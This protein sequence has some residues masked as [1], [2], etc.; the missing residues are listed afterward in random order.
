[1]DILKPRESFRFGRFEW[2]I[3][4]AYCALLAWTIAHH[5]P[6]ADEAQSWLLARDLSLAAIYGKYLHYEGTPGLWYLFLWFLVRLHVG[7]SLMHWI[8]G[9]V[10]AAGTWVFLRYSPFP[11][12]LRATLPF[13]FY[14]AYQYAV[15][16]RSYIA[17]P[18]CVF[19]A[20]TLLRNPLRHLMALA[21]V[22]GLLANLCAQG[23]V[24]SAGFAL[25][26]AARLLRRRSE[27]LEPPRAKN[28]AYAA[29]VLG[30]LWLGA[31]VTAAPASD[32][33]Y[34][35]VTRLMRVPGF[36]PPA[37][38][39]VS[40]ASSGNGQA[41]APPV[42]ERRNFLSRWRLLAVSHITDGLSSSAILSSLVMATVFA[43]LISKRRILDLAPYVLIVGFFVVVINRSWHIGMALLALIAVLWINWP[44]R[45][46][47]GD[48]KWSVMLTLA[49][50]FV[51]AE[52]CFWTVRAV[53]A[54]VHGEYA[55]DRDAA[56]FLRTNLK[57]KK[58]AGFQ[59]WS[60]GLLPYFPS[61]IYF[62][63]HR[64]GFWFW[65]STAHVDDRAMET[66][67]A[68]PDYIVI[69]FPITPDGVA[70]LGGQNA[71][72]KGPPA[73]W[74]EQEILATGLYKEAHRYCGSAFSG[75]GYSEQLCQAI[76]VAVAQ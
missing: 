27:S 1:M 14:L 39:A 75:R 17:V 56:A 66:L 69:G 62:N 25:I 9:A 73:P 29:A 60:I 70:Q 59:F 28:I 71:L 54:E 51:V 74:V 5:V 4:A 38:P 15:I 12:I 57:G 49:L 31:I 55:G 63:Q 68:H 61:N 6:W 2:A 18:L 33:D 52:Q 8:A 42:R 48:Q 53:A 32:N 13:T 11:Q 23:F 30:A 35:P 20:A 58:V 24:L 36:S 3:F 44:K 47:P 41:V 21:V 10:A 7:Y 19:L 16:A 34:F 40:P 67:K 65:S 43:F 46:T 76:L 22:L 37:Q 26:L 72:S 64:E 45:E 50:L